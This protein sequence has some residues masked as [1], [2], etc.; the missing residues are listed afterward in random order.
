[1][2]AS[3]CCS[4]VVRCAQKPMEPG[5]Y[6]RVEQQLMNQLHPVSTRGLHSLQGWSTAPVGENRIYFFSHINVS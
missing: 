6:D 1:M 2:N 4:N 5:D 3:C